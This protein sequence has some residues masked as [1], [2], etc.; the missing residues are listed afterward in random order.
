MRYYYDGSVIANEGDGTAI[1][2]SN[3]W[4][5]D[6]LRRD[7]NGQTGYYL[8]NGH[9]DVAAVIDPVGTELGTYTYDA[10][11]QVVSATGNLP[12][13]FRYA[14]E[15]LD[16]ETGFIYLRA[17]YYS[18]ALGRFITQDTW[19]GDP[20]DPSTQ[21]LYVYVGN[22][23]VNY[24]DPTGHAKLC[25]ACGSGN[26][27]EAGATSGEASV[28]GRGSFLRRLLGGSPSQ[29]QAQPS[30][31]SAAEP[32]AKAPPN[33]YGK[34]GSPAHRAVVEEVK[35]KIVSRPGQVLESRGEYKI[36]TPR[37][38]KPVRYADVVALDAEGNVVE[39]HQVGRITK[40]GQLVS[41]EVRAMQDISR[42]TGVPVIFHPYIV[43]QRGG[44]RW[45]SRFSSLWRLRTRPALF[46]RCLPLAQ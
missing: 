3:V 18:P 25:D 13:P 7:A 11:G 9:G 22:D 36:N 42:S 38:S 8:Y 1:T 35:T 28:G 14:G 30:G 46:R 33:P 20:W 17:R 40:S 34:L 27:L 24:V 45:V 39:I 32:A 43:D 15:P 21:N 37:G 44:E 31:Q 16:E 29:G 12:N 19:N 4:G 41:R 23:P 5:L 10:F 6:L 26:W 2:A